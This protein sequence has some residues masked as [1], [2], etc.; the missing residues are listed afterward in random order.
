[1]ANKEENKG[2]NVGE[3]TPENGGQDQNKEAVTEKQKGGLGT[4]VKVVVGAVV[5]AVSFGLGWLAKGL[6]SGR[7]EDEAVCAENESP[8]E[9]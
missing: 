8:T 9:E 1:M 3:Q 4:V 6:I 7:D 2:A 5:T